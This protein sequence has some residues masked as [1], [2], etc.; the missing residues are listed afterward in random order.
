MNTPRFIQPMIPDWRPL[1]LIHRGN[2]GDI[3]IHTNVDGKWKDVCAI[4]ARCLPGLF[5]QLIPAIERDSFFSLNAFAP[6]RKGMK[7]SFGLIDQ[8]GQPLP[9]PRRQKQWVRWL[10]T[11]FTDLDCYK[12]NLDVG[13]VI[14][15]VIN[16]QIAGDILPPSIIMRSGFGVWLMWLLNKP[17]GGFY[18]AFDDKLAIYER[19]QRAILSK[20]GNF[21]SDTAAKDAARVARIPGGMNCKIPNDPRRVDYWP[22]M[23][24]ATGT[25]NKYTLDELA[26]WLN[27][28]TTYEKRPRNFVSQSKTGNPLFIAR[29]A[30]ANAGRWRSAYEQFQR[31]WEIRG[32]WQP[33]TRNGAAFVLAVILKKRRDD[34][35]AVA[36]ELDEL[37][38]DFVKGSGDTAYSRDE[39][40]KTVRSVG[41]TSLGGMSD[42]HIADRLDVTPTESEMLGTLAKQNGWKGWP[43]ATRYA[44]D[45]PPRL[46]TAG[47]TRAQQT[48][49]R[50]DLVKRY[51]E[52][53][54]GVPSLNT[55]ADLVEAGGLVRPPASTIM[56]DL[57]K[58]GID[59]PRKWSGR[60]KDD[61][62]P[63]FDEAD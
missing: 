25:V 14:G 58:L 62:R 57:K 56:R 39:F 31:L 23:N 12:M 3:T 51:V 9:R 1:D 21:G 15:S 17:D 40:D 33:G 46:P 63:L 41:K 50:V 27:V 43:A 20:F 35:L 42:P 30:K 22:Q 47:L 16:A 37:F 6:Q 19:V 60:K 7:N 4:P 61:R 5:P 59:N 48:Q 18:G 28:P 54:K 29:A 11:A 13:T 49:R 52:T 10:L 55:L 44:T 38:R 36:R 8:D 26:A 2:D 53:L 34:Q 24:L 45:Q 32:T